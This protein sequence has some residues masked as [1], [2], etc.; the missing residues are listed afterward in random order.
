[1]NMGIG[2]FSQQ[3]D[4]SQL[5]FVQ[6]EDRLTELFTDKQLEILSCF[7]V[8]GT[9]SQIQYKQKV[10]ELRMNRKT[11][12]CI[13]ASVTAMARIHLDQSLRTL[14]SNGCQLIYTDTDSVV[15]RCK[16][17]TSTGLE[18][19]PTIFGCW[20]DEIDEDEEIKVFCGIGSKNYAYET[21]KKLSGEQGCRVTKI[22][23]LS[24]SGEVQ[25]EMDI[26]LMLDFVQKLQQG[27][28]ASKL[29]PQSRLAIDK[30]SRQIR[31]EDFQTVYSNFSNKKRFL[32]LEASTIRLWPYGVTIFN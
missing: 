20:A 24:L 18:I 7:L 8:T 21:V 23:G 25:E 12:V 1:M 6:N 5:E 32:N 10:T 17:G 26:D 28:K 3:P 14:Q 15:F 19:H 22:R 27:E 11:Q 16:K 13:G 30:V 9:T 31:A 29:V 4:Q 2:K